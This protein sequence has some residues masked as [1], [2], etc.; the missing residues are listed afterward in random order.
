MLCPFHLAE[1]QK[2]D[3]TTITLGEGR[4]MQTFIC[5][6]AGC[7]QAIPR[8]YVEEYSSYQPLLL[9]VVGFRDHGKSLFLASLVHVLR[10]ASLA[11][12]WPGFSAITLNNDT[13]KNIHEALQKLNQGVLPES[14]QAADFPA[15]GLLR[16]E[17]TLFHPGRTLLCYDTGGE[18]FKDPTTILKYASF[19][20]LAKAVLF[21]VSIADLADPST[22]LVRLLE[23]YI[24]GSSEIGKRRASQHL[25]VV[26][27]KAEEIEQL[28]GDPWKDI[29]E[30]AQSSVEDDPPRSNRYGHGLDKVSHRLAE[31]TDVG[32]RGA[33]FMN[34]A[35]AW[36]ASVEFCIVS[37]LGAAPHEG[38]LS[39]PLAPRRVIDPLIWLMAKDQPQTTPPSAGHPPPSRPTPTSFDGRWRT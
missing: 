29:A 37:A 23:T 17:P 15:P 19:V 32:L 10:D 34:A 22:D 16:L 6:V 36:F 14:T 18:V 25:I 3:S 7:E 33:S 26:F 38:R 11:R 5:P 30:Y 13:F 20:E 12:S 1:V 4:V 21:L 2:F 9:S 24:Q 35:R 28:R 8:V 31:F 27:T 39:G